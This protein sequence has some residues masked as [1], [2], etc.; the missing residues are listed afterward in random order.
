MK[1]EENMIVYCKTNVVGAISPPSS[2]PVDYFDV[3]KIT[4]SKILDRPNEWDT[5]YNYGRNY[6]HSEGQEW[7]SGYNNH[8]NTGNIMKNRYDEIKKQRPKWP[9]TEISPT[10]WASTDTDESKMSMR[11]L[12]EAYDEQQPNMLRSDVLKK[13]FQPKT[14]S[15]VKNWY[16]WPRNNISWPNWVPKRNPYEK[17]LVPWWST[18]SQQAQKA[19]EVARLTLAETIQKQ[20]QPF[21]LN[22]VGWTGDLGPFS[23]V[24]YPPW[25]SKN[26]TSNCC[27]NQLVY[28]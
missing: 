23:E 12:S 17:Q 14:G 13:Q 20:K 19:Q 15:E 11:G 24:P 18:D 5:E 22:S 28:V 2:Q 7:G 26:S 27:Q 9:Q 8:Y 6:K 1:I 21:L 3:D 4:Q 25:L 16:N 10:H